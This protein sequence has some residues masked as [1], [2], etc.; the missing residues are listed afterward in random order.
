MV[1]IPAANG[2]RSWVH[3]GIGGNP[4]RL[5]LS[6]RP[7]I[8]AVFLLVSMVSGTFWFSVLVTL[9]SSGLGLAITFLGLPVL[10]F[11]MFLWTCGARA[12]RWWISTLFGVQIPS[13]Y[14]P[15]PA[16]PLLGR[17]RV[18]VSDPAVWR[19]LC[20]LLVLFPLG[21]VEFIVTSIALLVPLAMVTL[22]VHVWA[23]PHRGSFD[24]LFNATLPEVMVITLIGFGALL[25]IPYALVGM[26]RAH[27]S[28]AQA[29]LGPTQVAL[30][31]RVDALTESRSRVMDAA[32]AERRRIER[33]LHDGA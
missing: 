29:L 8:A 17:L 13:P 31:A 14:R 9:I 4:L 27:I 12:E 3:G 25:V 5:L 32:L 15:L 11:T 24:P 6:A 16:G 20:Y 10:V 18:F 30:A 28:L 19:D 22:P 33:D 21:I 7:W 1:A 2:S 23:P 26:A